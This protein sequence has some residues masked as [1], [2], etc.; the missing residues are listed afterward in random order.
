MTDARPDDRPDDELPRS[1]VAPLTGEEV[2][3]RDE[4]RRGD[5]TATGGA[6]TRSEEELRIETV[7]YPVRRFRVRKYIVTEDVAVTVQ[8]RHEEISVEE[9]DVPAAGSAEP[10]QPDGGGGKATEPLEVILHREE[11]ELVKRI[12]PTERVRIT[13][14]TITEERQVSDQL[15]KEQI[16]LENDGRTDIL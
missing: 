2:R 5:A 10:V 4:L 6:M 3:S 9:I 11:Y 13:K 7:A 15:R 12:V 16:E 8:V 1:Q 14:Q